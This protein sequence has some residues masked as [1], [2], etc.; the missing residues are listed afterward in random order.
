MT[1]GVCVRRGA[2]GGISG[3]IAVVAAVALSGVFLVVFVPELWWMFTT[4]FWV[5]FPALARLSE[6]RGRAGAAD[7]ERELLA[8]LR[9]RGEIT[10]GMAA[11]ETSLSVAEAD[12]RLGKL[13]SDGHLQVRAHGGA[14]FY[15]LWEAEPASSYAEVEESRP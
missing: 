10:P 13:A 15:A 12:R 7:P 11:A 1:G 9:K 14:I 8:A 4:Y 5:A 2:S 6:A 3:A